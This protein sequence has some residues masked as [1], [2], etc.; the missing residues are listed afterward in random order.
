MAAWYNKDGTPR[1]DVERIRQ[2]TLKKQ[3]SDKLPRT[4][5]GGH[6]IWGKHR[7]QS[8]SDYEIPMNNLMSTY[9]KAAKAKRKA[10]K[11][12]R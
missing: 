1:L 3:R 7:L 10:K 12:K 11:A 6:D 2:K 9:E 4:K 8:E 5:A